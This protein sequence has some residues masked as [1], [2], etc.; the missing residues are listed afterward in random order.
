MHILYL[1]HSGAIED[2]NQKH[3][4]L[5]GISVFERQTYWL[6]RELDKIAARFN[7]ADPDSVELHGSPM[8]GGR[9]EWRRFPVADRVRA[10]SDSLALVAKSHPSNTLFGAVVEKVGVAPDDP[11]FL[12]FEYVCSA[13]DRYLLR[14]H[15]R[16]D[17][18]RGIIVLDKASYESQIQHLAADFRKI[19]HRWGIVTNLSEVPMFLDSRASRLIQLADLI[20]FSLYRYYEHKDDRFANI[21]ESRFDRYGGVVHGLTFC[22]KRPPLPVPTAQPPTI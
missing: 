21:I 7:P 9:H 19:G 18:Q 14:M 5:A 13:F 20:A 22:N 1:D 15:K 17:T 10:I 6:S 12:A 11:V 16:G 8:H 4:V 2:P 3:I